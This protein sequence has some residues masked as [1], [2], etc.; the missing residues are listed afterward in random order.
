[1]FRYLNTEK[2]FY[3]CNKTGYN[4]RELKPNVYSS[5]RKKERKE[6]SKK[7]VVFNL[8]TSSAQ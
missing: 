2:L 3:V 4:S 5:F 7:Y 1:M 6:H 8:E